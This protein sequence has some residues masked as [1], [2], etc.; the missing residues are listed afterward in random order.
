MNMVKRAMLEGEA[1]A[2]VESAFGWAHD[3]LS[4]NSPNRV[5]L[6][7]DGVDGELVLGRVTWSRRASQANARRHRNSGSDNP[8]VE[9]P[10]GAS[11]GPPAGSPDGSDP[12]QPQPTR[13]PPPGTTVGV[14]GNYH[15]NCRQHDQND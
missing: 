13:R 10:V 12:Q 9:V 15:L 6:M 14:C 1:P 5:P 7:T 8:G 4:K 11:T 3:Y 2:S